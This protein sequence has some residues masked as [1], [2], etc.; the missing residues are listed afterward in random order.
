MLLTYLMLFVAL[1]LSAVAAFYSIMGLAAIFA[2]AVVPI[3]IM[4]SILEVAKITTTIWLHEYWSQC[5][6]TMKAYLVPAV[7]IL[8]VL[9]SMGIFGF[10][11]KAH[12]D[13]SV[14]AGDVV[15]QVSL[16]DEKIKNERET[17]ANARTLL[18]QLDKA[19]NDISSAPDREVNG[20]VISSAERALQVRR[21]QARDRA[22]LSKTIE[23]AQARIVKLQEER[24]PIASQARKVEAEV[25]PIKYVAALIYGD[26]PDATTLERAV[27]WVII[28]IVAVFDPLA[29]MMLLAATESYKWERAQRKPPAPPIPEK[30]EEP[31]GHDDDNDAGT[32][33]S[34]D[35]PDSRD[36]VVDQPSP[37]VVPRTA[38]IPE[39][40]WGGQ[41]LQYRF[42]DPGIKPNQPVYVNMPDIV[43][44]KENPV[45]YQ[46]LDDVSEPD[47]YDESSAPAEKEID[48]E[49]LAKRAWKAAN[50]TDTIHRHEA[51]LEA[52]KIDRLPWMDDLRAR[53]DDENYTNVD[54]GTAFPPSPAKGDAYIRVDYLPSRLFKFNGT[55]WIEIDKDSTDSFTYNDNYIDHLIAKISSGEYDPELLNDN[56]RQQIEDRLRNNENPGGVNV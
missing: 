30:E 9:T 47:Y 20:R 11:S 38:S 3:V 45:D 10:L 24:A 43:P 35:G 27:R 37:E 23:E 50:P 1:C 14:P 32:T 26:N 16:F 19:V 29:I 15:A 25:G 46:V 41:D 4:G 2:A 49:K 53:A 31:H 44:K 8:M 18:N 17:I 13:Q 12:L 48:P 5:K 34:M 51:L 54:F 33:Q 55:K 42:Q 6:R 7:F 40:Q 28:L 22:A 56:E 39:H 21:Q 36:V 52:G